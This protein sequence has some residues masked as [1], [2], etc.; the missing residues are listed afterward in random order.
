VKTFLISDRSLFSRLTSHNPTLKLR[1]CMTAA[2]YTMQRRSQNRP[3]PPPHPAAAAFGNNG[4]VA[5]PCRG[6]CGFTGS[7]GDAVVEALDDGP[8]RVWT[9]GRY[10]LQAARELQ[11]GWEL[12]KAGEAGVPSIHAYLRNRGSSR[13]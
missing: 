9:D 5:L 4:P 1:Q 13:T 10:W 12:M 3:A 11:P 7:A 6:G 2:S 8:A